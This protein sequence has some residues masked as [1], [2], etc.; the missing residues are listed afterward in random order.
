MSWKLYTTRFKLSV[1]RPDKKFNW[2]SPG[3]PYFFQRSFNP[4]H[5]LS[6][7]SVQNPT[8]PDQLT[9]YKNVLTNQNCHIRWPGDW[10]KNIFPR[11]INQ[12]PWHFV[13]CF[14]KLGKRIIFVPVVFVRIVSIFCILVTRRRRWK[15]IP[16]ISVQKHFLTFARFWI[17]LTF[18]WNQVTIHVLK[19]QNNM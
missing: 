2:V 17:S 12:F 4:S 7:C 11:Q 6:V 10:K 15:K 9:V 18:L 8:H 5:I 1:W 3:S 19:S 14:S 13:S 16:D